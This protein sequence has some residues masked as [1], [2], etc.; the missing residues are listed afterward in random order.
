[1]TWE[2]VLYLATVASVAVII[3]YAGGFIYGLIHRP[4]VLFPPKLAVKMTAAAAVGAPFFLCGGVALATWVMN[5]EF[6]KRSDFNLV[7]NTIAGVVISL[8]GS[9]A[10]VYIAA[11]LAWSMLG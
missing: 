7:K 9:I 4:A 8:V 5:H 1:M 3:F 11:I 6:Q 10:S 2:L